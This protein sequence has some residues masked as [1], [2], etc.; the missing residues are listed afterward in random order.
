MLQ[1]E[2]MHV[3]PRIHLRFLDTEDKGDFY[4]G[5]FCAEAAE[6]S[7]NFTGA[8]ATAAEAIIDITNKAYQ[9]TLL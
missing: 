4:P 2:M 7:F 8:A 5:Q 9:T 1:K 6:I 3:V